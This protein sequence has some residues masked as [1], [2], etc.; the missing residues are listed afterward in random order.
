VGLFEP[1]ADFARPG[2]DVGIKFP[3]A[4]SPPAADDDAHETLE[5][6]TG[7]DRFVGQMIEPQERAIDEP[8]PKIAVQKDDAELDLVES[9]TQRING[10]LRRRW[11]SNHLKFFVG[12]GRSNIGGREVHAR[13][14]YHAIR[15]PK[16]ATLQLIMRPVVERQGRRTSRDDFAVILLEPPGRGPK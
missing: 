12:V 5:I 4:Q 14:I 15:A 10:L 16:A 2:L 7:D 11:I 1:G 3:R 6:E 8:H 9:R 13:R